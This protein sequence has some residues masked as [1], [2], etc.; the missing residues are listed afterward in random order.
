M[1]TPLDI[2]L[3]ALCAA[4]LA[5][6]I[7]PKLRKAFHHTFS[8]TRLNLSVRVDGVWIHG[9]H[10]E[11][12]LDPVLAGAPVHFIIKPTDAATGKT[13]DVTNIVWAATN[14]QIAPATDGLSA[15]YVAPASGTDTVT[16]TA[17]S[18]GGAALS[19]DA[20]IT[21]TVPVVE[22]TALNLQVG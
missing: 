16:V 2:L 7:A 14:G 21:V 8:H 4:F 9:D 12:T 13:G 5:L 6:V 3:A 10:L 17:T 15:A 1:I 20:L 18:A 19:D 22:V 11:I